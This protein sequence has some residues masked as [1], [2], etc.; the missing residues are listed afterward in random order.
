MKISGKKEIIEAVVIAALTTL[1][2]GLIE[3]GLKKLDP[4]EEDK[5]KICKG[6]CQK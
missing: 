4:E 1:F 3:W 2:N 6:S 5:C